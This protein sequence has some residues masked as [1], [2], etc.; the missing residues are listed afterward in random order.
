MITNCTVCGKITA[1]PYPQFY[2]YR[3]GDHWFCSDNC[4][5]VWQ[6]QETRRLA[7]FISRHY[8]NKE[9]GMKNK[10]I[11]LEQKK[12]AVEIAIHG[13]D[14]VDYLK[15]CGSKNASAHWFYIRKV[16][17][18][19][20]PEKYAKLPGADGKLKV[21]QVAHSIDPLTGVLVPDKE[22]GE[23]NETGAIVDKGLDNKVTVAE[24]YE[25][26]GVPKEAA[27]EGECEDLPAEE[28]VIIP[29]GDGE[30]IRKYVDASKV[31]AGKLTTLETEN[32]TE[33]DPDD[34]PT[35]E[36]LLNRTIMRNGIPIIPSPGIPSI[37]SIK[38]S[39][40]TFTVTSIRG[41]FG[42]YRMEKGCMDFHGTDGEDLSYTIGAWIGFME[43]I[44]SAM[45][46]LGVKN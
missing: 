32:E 24:M 14:P 22:A 23:V 25:A 37:P 41:K 5:N 30:A 11:T 46:I 13:G 45:E 18:E 39:C 28:P 33:G 21:E 17:K 16:L 8:E 31:A 15:K 4:M 44:R 34:G 19:K 43:E 42:E 36:D 3:R 12:Q 29:A 2:V 38:A 27:E 40:G 9:D 7:G 6:T 20:D 10:V 35:A 26:L 1:I